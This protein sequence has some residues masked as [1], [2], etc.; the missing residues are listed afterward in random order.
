MKH[1]QL[2]FTLFISIQLA[3]QTNDSRNS[4]EWKKLNR[5]IYSLRIPS[6]WKIDTSRQ[7]GT[8]LFLI[9]PKEDSL[10]NFVENFNTYIQ[11]LNGL[12]YTLLKM[13]QESE[14]QIKRISNEVEIIESRL[15]SD[16]QI[17]YYSLKYRSRQGIFLLLT[18]QRYYLINE[19]GFALTF[20]TQ[21]GKENQYEYISNEIFNSFDLI[22]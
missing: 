3:A 13:G 14:I 4:F 9:S 21:K 20:T 7:F 11:D 6:N 22:K 17:P 12:N 18:E 8:D 2:I 15:E 16:N 10:D 1:L 19:A 5:N